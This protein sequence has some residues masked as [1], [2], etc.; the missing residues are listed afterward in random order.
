MLDFKTLFSLIEKKEYLKYLVRR[1][2]DK[3]LG[4]NSLTDCFTLDID[5]EHE[6]NKI[7]QDVR[8]YVLSYIFYYISKDLKNVDISH[9]TYTLDVEDNFTCFISIFR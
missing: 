5:I 9:Y 3:C 1:S 4:F 6:L 8:G 2:L 7:S